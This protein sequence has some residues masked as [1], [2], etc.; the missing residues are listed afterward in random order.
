M[1]A[2]PSRSVSTRRGA[3]IGALVTAALAG[4]RVLADIVSRRFNASVGQ[5]FPGL[6]W[7]ST[8]VML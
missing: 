8:G 1:T 6:T 2:A 5:V 4:R 3:I 7:Q